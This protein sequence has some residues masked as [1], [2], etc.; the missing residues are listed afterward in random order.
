MVFTAKLEQNVMNPRGHL[1]GMCGREEYFL[2]EKGEEVSFFYDPQNIDERTKRIISRIQSG[3]A[4]PIKPGTRREAWA[5]KFIVT[6]H[7]EYI[8]EE[9]C[10]E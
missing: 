3:E 6:D 2:H 10:E 9:Y 7:S 1:N 4:F 8:D 5:K